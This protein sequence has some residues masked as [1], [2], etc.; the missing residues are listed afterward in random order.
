MVNRW[1]R[2]RN[3]YSGNALLPSRASLK[4]K[5]SGKTTSR[6]AR[7]AGACSFVPGAVGLRQG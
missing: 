6:P 5:G 2:I 1:N 4:V 3:A 7:K